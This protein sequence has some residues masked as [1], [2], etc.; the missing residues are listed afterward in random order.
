MKNVHR[1]T[2]TVTSIMGIIAGV[3]GIEHGIGELLQGN[4]RPQ[5][6]VFA[7]WPESR[8]FDIMAGEPA[9]SLIPNMLISG[10]ITILLAVYVIYWAARRMGQKNGGPVLIG[11]SVML[12]LVGGGFGPPLLGIILGTVSI[13]FHRQQTKPNRQ[14]PDGFSLKVGQSW[15]II[16]GFTLCFWLFLFPILPGLKLFFI[17]QNEQLVSITT[18]LAFTFLG[19]SI[20][21]AGVSDRIR[22]QSNP[23]IYQAQS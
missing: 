16:F 15:K 21:S 5:H 9:M 1:A 7:S 19:L 2:I 11:L 13:F 22:Q 10:I 6:I 3:A 17:I 8:L 4:I 23:E 12:L 20:F 14:Q 18:L